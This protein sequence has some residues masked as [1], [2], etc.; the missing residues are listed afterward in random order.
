MTA[1][2]EKKHTGA[3]SVLD[4]LSE[5]YKR[6]EGGLICCYNELVSLDSMNKAIPFHYL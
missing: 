1:S 3:F 5:P 2:P 6:G 4:T